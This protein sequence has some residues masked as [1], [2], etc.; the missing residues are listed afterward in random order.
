M[1]ND[2]HLTR[3][4][5]SQHT[6]SPTVSNSSMLPHNTKKQKN[7]S[8]SW[9]HFTIV[10]EIG[11]KVECNYCEKLIKYNNGTSYMCAHLTRCRVCKRQRTPSSMISTYD[12]VEH[13]VP[14]FDQEA[15]QSAFVKMFIN[16]EIPFR[17]VEHESF[18]EFM[19]LSKSLPHYI[20]ADFLSKDINDSVS[21]IRRVVWYI[22]SSGLR[23]DAFKSNVNESL[24]YKVALKHETTFEELSFQDKRY[25]NEMV[26]KGKGV[27]TQ[28]HWEHIS[29]GD[30]HLR[31]TAQAMKKKYDKYWRNY[32]SINMMLL[33]AL[34][35]DPRRKVKLTY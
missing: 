9:N 11:K 1:S 19:T 7:H 3:S 21:R 18:H 25:V 13:V 17:K 15:I 35:F 5:T 23:L 31:S 24:E 29:S 10:D 6:I 14:K 2:G 32:K 27:P 34:V 4:T 22:R 20:Y 30:A 8:K 26:K 16:M 33:I 28:G 12:H